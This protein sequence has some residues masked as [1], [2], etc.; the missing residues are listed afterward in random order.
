MSTLR[1]APTLSGVSVESF[2]RSFFFYSFS[3]RRPRCFVLDFHLLYCRWLSYSLP[4]HVWPT[5][6]LIAN[7]VRVCSVSRTTVG[8]CDMSAESPG[9][10]CLRRWRSLSNHEPELH[11]M[12]P[13]ALHSSLERREFIYEPDESY[14]RSERSGNCWRHRRR[15]DRRWMRGWRSFL[16]CEEE[17]TCNSGYGCMA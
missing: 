8:L 9:L 13:V 3:P 6:R 16:V 5:S 2:Y 11:T 12:C 15:S 4:L 17:E 10:S 7:P 14:C 1:D